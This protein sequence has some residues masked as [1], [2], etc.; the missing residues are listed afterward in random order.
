MYFPFIYDNYLRRKSHCNAAL[1]SREGMLLTAQSKPF[2]YAV[3]A[4]DTLLFKIIQQLPALADQLQKASARMMIFFVSLEMLG[5]IGDS[6][7]QKCD[8]YF[9]RSGI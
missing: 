9:G 7:A 1:G 2:D 8:L 3:I 5:Q 4:V 6:L